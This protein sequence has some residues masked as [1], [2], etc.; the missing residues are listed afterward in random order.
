MGLRLVGVGVKWG[1][2][3]ILPT[4]IGFALEMGTARKMKL[5]LLLHAK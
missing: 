3:T 5:E 4:K 2:W 1:L